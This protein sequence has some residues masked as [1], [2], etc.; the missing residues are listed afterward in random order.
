[1]K[2]NEWLLVLALTLI[3]ITSLSFAPPQSAGS[4]AAVESTQTADAAQTLRA[5]AVET[6]ARPSPTPSATATPSPSPTSSPTRR[7]TRTPTRTPTLGPTPY[8]FE[9]HAELDRYMYI[10]QASQYI[11]I[12]EHGVLLR[13]IPCSTGL[14]HSDKYTPGWSGAVGHYVGTFFSFDV[15]ADEAWYLFQSEGGILIHSLPY[16][17][18]EDGTKLYLE[19]EL[20]GVRPSSH[21]CVRIAPEDAEWLT[22]WNPEGVAATVSDPYLEKWQALEAEDG[23]W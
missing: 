20:L 10:D 1:M 23:G 12:F 8:P 14:P 15:Y 13:A 19:R 11:Y 2:R 6:L 9:T 21:G 16:L 3:T 22:N 5:T 7:P 18:A 4:R 17:P